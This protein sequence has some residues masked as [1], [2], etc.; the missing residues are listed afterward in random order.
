MGPVIFFGR[1]LLCVQGGTV[2]AAAKAHFPQRVQ[3]G[4]RA[5][6]RQAGLVLAVQP[7]LQRPRL[8]VHKFDGGPVEHPVRHPLFHRAAQNG[9]HHVLYAFHLLDV[10][11]G[12]NVNAGF[13]QF[14]YIL[15]P[16]HVAAVFAVGVGQIVDQKQLRASCQAGVQIQLLLPAAA[17]S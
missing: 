7:L 15:I 4:Q 17:A 8:D 13:Q 6:V 1:A 3:P 16:L 5:A 12:V 2:G 11:R 10:Q 9:Q 14:F